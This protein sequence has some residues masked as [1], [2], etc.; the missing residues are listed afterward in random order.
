MVRPKRNEIRMI[1][2]LSG[3]C[4][5]FGNIPRRRNNNKSAIRVMIEISVPS[6]TA[7]WR[8]VWF[9]LHGGTLVELTRH[10][11]AYNY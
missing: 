7:S 11:V 8:F 6:I 3:V 1:Q 5:V 10:S 2:L 9:K 4:V